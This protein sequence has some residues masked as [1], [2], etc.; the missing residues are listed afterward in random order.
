MINTIIYLFFS[1]I[2]YVEVLDNSTC[3]YDTLIPNGMMK[4]K[5]RLE[6]KL[7][8]FVIRVSKLFLL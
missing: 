1:E 2:I 3:L 5:F 8:Y 4:L 6:S 7:N